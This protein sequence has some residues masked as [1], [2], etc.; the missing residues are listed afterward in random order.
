[1]GYVC[2]HHDY[3]VD[4]HIFFSWGLGYGAY[5]GGNIALHRILELRVGIEKH[6]LGS[7]GKDN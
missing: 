3:E 1:M 4:L 5:I 7:F 6:T 2:A